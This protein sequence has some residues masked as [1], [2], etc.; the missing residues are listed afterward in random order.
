MYTEINEGSVTLG[1]DHP[2]KVAGI[3]IIRMR[4]FDRMVWTLMNVKHIP[5]LKKNLVSLGY[6]ER[7]GYSFNS[8]ARDRVLN[9]SNGAMIVMGRRLENNLYK[10]ER[11]VVT[12]GSD[13]A[14]A[15]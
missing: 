13:I 15:T 14:T 3:K 6:M 2:S 12:G 8:H 9:I 1:D 4:M 7:S 5:K 10:M 11:S